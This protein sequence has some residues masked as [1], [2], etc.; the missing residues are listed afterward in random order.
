LSDGP[1]YSSEGQSVFIHSA[2]IARYFKTY[3]D[4]IDYLEEI[5]RKY[6]KSELLNILEALYRGYGTISQDQIHQKYEI[7]L[8]E[9]LNRRFFVN[10][11]VA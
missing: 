9:T 2:L 1:L 5:N 6:S 10:P 7:S 4:F 3:A 11:L 8:P